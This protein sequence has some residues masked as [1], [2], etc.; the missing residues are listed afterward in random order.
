VAGLTVVCDASVL[1]AHLDAHDAHHAEA[2]RLLLEHA[3]E[4]LA[5]SVITIA[6]VLVGPARAGRLADAQRALRDLRLQ[7]VALPADAAPR[8][9]ELGATTGLKLPDCCVLHARDAVTAAAVLTFDARLAA[10][11][12]A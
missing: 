7:S 10:A 5:A 3:D 1:I 6:E 9:A 12:A 11:A 2:G 4:R 8:L